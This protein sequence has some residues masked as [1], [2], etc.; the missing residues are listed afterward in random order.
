MKEFKVNDFIT[1]KL[2][3]EETNIYVNGALFD[4]CKF[5]MLNIPVEETERFDDI[6]SIDEAADMLGWTE[7][8]Q[9]GVTYDIDPETEFWG[10][11]SNLQAW[12]E[13]NYDTRLLH[14]NLAFPLLKKLTVVGDPLAKN[15]FKEEIIKRF[16]SGY[17]PVI[18][19]IVKTKLLDFLNNEERE[20]LLKLYFSNILSSIEKQ[21]IVKRLDSINDMINLSKGTDLLE[22]N[23]PEILKII[24]DVFPEYS[25][26]G[27]IS[28][29]EIGKITGGIKEKFIAFL[30]LIKDLSDYEKQESYF[31]LL[32]I[33]KD[34]GGI[35]KPFLDIL[36][37][38]FEEYLV[39]VFYLLPRLSNL[40]TGIED[41]FFEILDMINY[42]PEDKFY[43][44]TLY[45][46]EASL[47][48][49]VFSVLIRSIKNSALLNK[50]TSQN[51]SYY[52]ALLDS[53]K[54][55]VDNE[56]Y[57]AFCE[58]L[59][60]I[61]NDKEG[62]KELYPDFLK[63]IDLMPEHPPWEKEEALLK[64]F[65]V[66]K[67]LGQIEEN[68]HYFLKTMEN[69][70]KKSRAFSLSLET[71]MDT[72]LINKFFPVFLK[73]VESIDGQ[74]K[75]EAINNLIKVLKECGE[76]EKYFFTF[77]NVIEEI[78]DIFYWEFKYQTIYDLFN[79]I[80]TELRI[81]YTSQIK[82]KF[83]TYLETLD[84]IPHKYLRDE[85]MAL[86]NI[87]VDFCWI[88]D[89]FPTFLRFR[90]SDKFPYDFNSW[91]LKRLLNIAKEEGLFKKYF[92]VFMENVDTYI[93]PVLL[94]TTRELGW[95]EENF[96]SFFKA[97]NRLSSL[98]A[99]KTLLDLINESD[100]MDKYEAQMKAYFISYLKDPDTHRQEFFNIE[101]NLFSISIEMEWI[102]ELFEIF[103]D[104]IKR[105]KNSYG[106][107]LLIK[108]TKNSNV[109]KRNSNQVEKLI[110][111]L[112]DEIK[113]S[114]KPT[115][116]LFSNLIKMTK[117]LEFLDKYFPVFLEKIEVF[118]Q[119]MK[120]EV[121][122]FL[123]NSIKGTNVLTQSYSQILVQ[124]QSLLNDINPKNL[125][126][127]TKTISNTEY[128]P[129]LYSQIKAKF[130]YL[131]THFEYDHFHHHSV[132][133]E[134]I[135]HLLEVAKMMGWRYEHFST[136]LGFIETKCDSSLFH[137]LLNAAIEIDLV[138]KNFLVFMRAIVEIHFQYQFNA[139][140]KLLSVKNKDE[141]IDHN[142]L[143][144]LRTIDEYKKYQFASLQQY[145]ALSYLISTT[146]NIELFDKYYSEI[147][148]L[149]FNLLLNITK[150]WLK[151]SYNYGLHSGHFPA[152][153]NFF[154]NLLEKLPSYRKREAY[155][156]F[157]NYIDTHLIT[158]IKGNHLRKYKIWKEKNGVS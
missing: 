21:S 68:F 126:L 111:S 51:K 78:P 129:K 116:A 128:I 7:E 37:N 41:H 54:K 10:H 100:L 84:K 79:S 34:I 35:E 106:L 131:L 3:G 45:H 29:I 53:I 55:F 8:R 46:D 16:E 124:F 86:I 72:K 62:I 15:V 139:F 33:A 17:S 135:A 65:K 26:V 85:L 156:N 120:Y 108:A 57:D 50:K 141:L 83:Y 146:Q 117:E 56:K 152:L 73:L 31:T 38:I 63:I 70:E 133:N 69:L 39:E 103:L 19:F 105:N 24:D 81:K 25:A 93:F 102:E 107:L 44:E 11:C 96:P 154:S 101:R 27:F 143:A 142:F 75:S 115:R 151:W 145:E 59:E 14:S 125:L 110:Q 123:F 23:L 114:D 90:L 144:I 48:F 153:L 134:G 82:N 52:L 95:F 74:K 109:L 132:G 92:S 49:R 138:K 91:I 5:L 99:Y 149:C 94:T 30:Y 20:H 127:L 42:F 76:L 104:I 118:H 47:K 130:Q 12:Y 88:K 2:E 122:S 157:V 119:N 137:T 9:E 113:K 77:L 80:N 112:I 36:D 60:L 97:L 6:E 66:A 1:L 13:H 136:F 64:L 67:D 147:E 4:Q 18:D 58:L 28:L 40:I 43:D 98:Q 71:A 87:A 150:N 140:S 61:K 155:S 148:A 121:F 89:V 158:Y 22:R 32:E